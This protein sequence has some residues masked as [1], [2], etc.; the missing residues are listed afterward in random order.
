MA[1]IFDNDKNQEL[2]DLIQKNITTSYKVVDEYLA[3]NPR[4]KRGYFEWRKRQELPFASKNE[5][6][7]EIVNMAQDDGTE[8]EA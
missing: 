4:F 2:Y 3:K 6:I 7:W 5:A 1:N 8:F